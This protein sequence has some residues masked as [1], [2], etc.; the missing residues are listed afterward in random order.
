MIR[1]ANRTMLWAEI[2]VE[3]LARSGLTAVCIAPGSRS[4][5]LMLAFA[6]QKR[7]TVY[8]HIDER[9]A[10]FFALGLALAT[11]APVAVLCTSGTAAAEFYPA[12]VEANYAEV[13][14]L[15]LTADR[16]HEA[17]AS[18]SNQTVNQVNLYGDHVRWF[19][20]VAPPEADPDPLVLRYLRALAARALTAASAPPAG[21]VHLNFPFRKPL[22]PTPV[23]DDVPERL[24]TERPLEMTGRANGRA[25]TRLTRGDN[26][27]S[28]TQI[29]LLA[30]AIESAPQGVIICGPR[31]P[32]AGFPLAVTHLARLTGYPVFA[33][34]LSGVRFG[35]QVEQSNGLILG[36]YETFLQRTITAHWKPPEV[37]LRFGGMPTSTA[38]M[39]WLEGI[40]T[41]RHILITGSGRW[42]DDTH[43]LAELIWADPELT[44]QR[45]TA[46][47]AASRQVQP[48]SAWAESF[49]RVENQ[50]WEAVTAARAAEN[51]EGAVL[52]EV[53]EHLPA[54][55][56]LF[57]A[58]S[59]PVRHLDQFVRPSAKDLRVFANRGA[60]GIDGTISS[61]LGVAAASKGPLV[62]VMGDLAFYHDLN[63]LL[64]LRRCGVKATI[65]VINNDGGGIFQR[66]PIAK[67]DP[68]FTELVRTPHG[69]TFAPAAQMFGADYVLA[70]GQGAFQRALEKAVGSSAS[71]IIE[72]PSD[73]AHF[74]RRRRELVATIAERATA[75]FDD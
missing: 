29:N 16:S 19:V 61:A 62:L 49:Q 60:S 4:T 34:A 37:I 71:T 21:P 41:A 40:A 30:E 67:F 2:F 8:P 43:H 27:P 59:L 35:R 15:I 10:A 33:D 3:E 25:F 14:L 31:C 18:G 23:P 12:I 26:S 63:G 58:S 7:I 66:L 38:L 11:Q 70:E 5:P 73:S 13:P 20:D 69:L 74:E 28:A 6:A 57:V 45:L 39:T 55:A 9:S 17:R 36:G 64:A 52:A 50:V 68:P 56:A 47:L 44:C 48:D 42:A 72:V 75:L 46:H 22:E 53:V 54:G 24:W 32:A 65:V 51:F 1:A